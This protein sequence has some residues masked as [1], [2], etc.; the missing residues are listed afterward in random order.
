[1]PAYNVNV[2]LTPSPFKD[3]S[4]KRLIGS[5]VMEGRSPSHVRNRVLRD[6]IRYFVERGSCPIRRS[7]T[8]VTFTGPSGRFRVEVLVSRVK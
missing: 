7:L 2:Y 5:G 8:S 6:V 3:R 1:M 4:D